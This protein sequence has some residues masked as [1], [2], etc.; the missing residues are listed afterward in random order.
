MSLNSTKRGA[1]DRFL[2]EPM[3]EDEIRELI[4]EADN[5]ENGTIDY[6]EF[7]SMMNQKPKSSKN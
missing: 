1:G 3:T 6:S 4:E 5:D 2:G 7:Y